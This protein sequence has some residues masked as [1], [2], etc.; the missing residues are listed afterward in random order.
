[1]SLKGKYFTESCICASEYPLFFEG[2]KRFG[3]LFGGEKSSP[4]RRCRFAEAGGGWEMRIRFVHK[5]GEKSPIKPTFL[6]IT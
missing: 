5:I 2:E 6:R 3:G 1:M 4:K